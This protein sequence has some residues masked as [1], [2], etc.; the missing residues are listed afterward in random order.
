MITNIKLENFRAFQ[1][2]VSVRIRPITVLVGRN[3]AGKS[4]LLKFLLML[5]QTLDSQSDAFFVTE[6]RHVQLGIW[7]DLRNSRSKEP[8]TMDSY[9]RYTIETETADLPKDEVIEL[10]RKSTRSKFVTEL[11]GKYL[12]HVELPKYPIR[13]QQTKG[14]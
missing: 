9:F 11:A 4:S 3:S 10:W 13:Q 8:A 1:K 7:K 14:R 2:E 5:R 6:G 12:L